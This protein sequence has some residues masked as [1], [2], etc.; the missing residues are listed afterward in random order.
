MNG[1]EMGW[2]HIPQGLMRNTFNKILVRKPERKGAFERP[3]HRWNDNI[4][5]YLT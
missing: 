2:L 3:C 4:Q 5:I 1:D